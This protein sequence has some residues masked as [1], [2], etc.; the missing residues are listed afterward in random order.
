MR[1][2]INLLFNFKGMINRKSFLLGYVIDIIVVF[3]GLYLSDFSL[4]LTDKLFSITLSIVSLSITL[5]AVVSLVALAIKRFRDFGWTPLLIL[6]GLIPLYV[7]IPFASGTVWH[8]PI[9]STLLVLLCAL[10]PGKKAK[11]KTKV[12]A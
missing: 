2:L 3:F 4:T 5:V 8:I 10:L 6:L 9:I 7:N 11:H 1:N 12:K